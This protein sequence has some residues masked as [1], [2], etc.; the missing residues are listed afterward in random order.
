MKHARCISNH[1]NVQADRRCVFCTFYVSGLT[2]MNMEKS[3]SIEEKM[4]SSRLSVYVR[5][6][7]F[8]KRHANV[9]HTLKYNIYD[10]MSATI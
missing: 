10:E 5:L 1:I 6:G 2:L 3:H 8:K 4:Q 7:L 9:V